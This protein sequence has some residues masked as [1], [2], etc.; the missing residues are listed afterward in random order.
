MLH[1]MEEGGLLIHY[2]ENVGG[3][4]RKYYITTEAGQTELRG[5]KKYLAELVRE[6]GLQE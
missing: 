4:I 5:A 6:I 2:E 3:R 1:A